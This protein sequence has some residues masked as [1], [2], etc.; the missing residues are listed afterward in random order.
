MS[1]KTIYIKTIAILQIMAQ[2]GCFV[3]ATSA[4]LRITD[5]LFSRI[6]FQ[7]SIEQKA[8][9]LTVELRDME[10]IYSNLTPNSLVVIDELFRSTNPQE[11]EVMCWKFCEKLLKFIGLSEENQLKSPSEAMETDDGTENS[12]DKR[13]ASLLRSSNVK[14][15]DVARPFVFFTTHFNSLTKLSEKYNNAIK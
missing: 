1:G 10:Y 13:N 5:K 14:L 9:S 7:D 8:S 6:G 3:P 2:I 11:G 15:K 4:M 12:A